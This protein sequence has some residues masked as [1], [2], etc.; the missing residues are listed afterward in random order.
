MS[1]CI[2]RTHTT[3]ASYHLR[4]DSSFYIKHDKKTHTQTLETCRCLYHLTFWRHTVCLA[5]QSITAE[6]K[7][8]LPLVLGPW[9]HLLNTGVQAPARESLQLGSQGGAWLPLRPELP[10]QAGRAALPELLLLHCPRFVMRTLV[11]ANWVTSFSHTFKDICT[12]RLD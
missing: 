2:M 1:D 6:S 4:E 9:P 12:R 11:Q 10:G 8:Q 5:R 7:G 3:E